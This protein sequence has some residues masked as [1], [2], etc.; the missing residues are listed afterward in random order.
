MILLKN[1]MVP[2]VPKRVGSFIHQH[3]EPCLCQGR[4]SHGCGYS[5]TMNVPSAVENKLTCPRY[6]AWSIVL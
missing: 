4:I 5:R 2:M 1:N 3:T 6:R